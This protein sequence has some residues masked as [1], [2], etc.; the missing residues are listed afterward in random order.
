[1]E[2]KKDNIRYVILN[3]KRDTYKKIENN[4]NWIP[5]LWVYLRRVSKLKL[6]VVS[7]KPDK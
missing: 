3:H 1:M 6:I 7:S 4:Q 5:V 2:Y